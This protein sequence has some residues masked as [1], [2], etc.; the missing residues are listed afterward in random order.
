M[1]DALKPVRC[2]VSPAG[3]DKIADWYNGLSA[4]GRADTDEFIKNMRKTDE[5]KMP[6]YRPRLK[7]YAGLGELRWTS[8]KKEHR[9]IGYLRGGVFFAVMGCTHKGSIYDPANALV[10]S[11]RRKSHIQ[12]GKAVTVAYD[13]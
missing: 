11:D 12:N 9:M 5:W 13:L 4:Q 3:N 7:G 10:E 8:E 1:A 6:H 2:Y